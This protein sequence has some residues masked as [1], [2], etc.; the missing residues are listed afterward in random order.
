MHFL[1]PGRQTSE[2]NYVWIWLILCTEIADE[3]SQGIKICHHPRPCSLLLLACGGPFPTSCPLSYSAKGWV[4]WSQ[5]SCPYVFIHLAKTALPSRPAYPTFLW[6]TQCCSF[7]SDLTFVF[8]DF[9]DRCLCLSSDTVTNYHWLSD[10]NHR[11]LYF[12]VPGLQNPRWTYKFLGSFCVVFPWEMWT[13][14]HPSHV[15]HWQQRKGPFQPTLSWC[16]HWGSFQ[17]HQWLKSPDSLKRL[18]RRM[19]GS[20]YH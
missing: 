3:C 18:P 15:E 13:D 16:L 14:I 11:H 20:S 9:K 7:N 17:E 2:L 10:L 6:L 8:K 1:S 5:L 12:T 4:T 19:H